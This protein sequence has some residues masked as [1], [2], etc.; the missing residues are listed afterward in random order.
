MGFIL[1]HPY[2]PL[3]SASVSN[4][5]QFDDIASYNTIIKLLKEKTNI[6]SK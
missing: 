5:S 2:D 4:M 3:T 6:E 1:L